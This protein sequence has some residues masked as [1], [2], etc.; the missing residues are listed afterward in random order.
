[1]ENIQENVQNTN[2]SELVLDFSASNITEFTYDLEK[3]CLFDAWFAR[4]VDLFE[5]D[6]SKLDDDAKVPLVLRNLN[7]TAHERYTSFIL[8]KPSKEFTF[9]ETFAQLKTIFGSP[10]STFHRR[11]QC[12][13]TAKEENED[14]ITY[15]CRVNRACVD[16]K[17]QVL[18]VEQLKA[19]IFVCGL[20][21]PKGVDI[22]MRLLSNI[23][24][25][26]DITLEKIVEKCKIMINLKKDTS[27]IGRKVPLA[28]VESEA[29]EGETEKQ[30][31]PRIKDCDSNNITRN[32]RYLETA[33]NE[34]PVEM[35]LGSGSGITIISKQN[36]INVG[37]PRTSPPDCK[38]QTASGDKLNI[39]AMFRATYTIG[40][41]HKE[42]PDL[43]DEFGLWD[44]PFSSFFKLVG[45]K[46]PD[47][48]VADLKP[49]FPDAFT[50]RMGRCT[51][52]QVHLTLKPAF[53]L[54]WPVSYNMEAVVEDEL[55]RLVN[56]GIITP[57]TYADWAALIVVVRKPDYPLPLPE[58]IF[59]RLANCKMFSHI[60]FS[61]AY[62]QV[63]LDEESR[64]FVT[65]T[66]T[67]GYR[68]N[69]ISPGVKC[70]SGAFQQI[71]DAMLSGLP[72]ASA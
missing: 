2:Q 14:F 61:D 31:L 20:R 23:N 34:V 68:F 65:I 72:C 43:M 54:N 21:S 4:Y 59:N 64:N 24:E 42:G 41:T 50:N 18:K 3:G 45:S 56:L 63:K 25:T 5:K 8:P 30:K 51:K 10:V 1:M 22:R 66:L 46:Q 57:V 69:R 38:V 28:T 58:D 29:I 32:W 55:K 12:L 15:S 6:A 16:F 35:Q 19:L 33:I 52:T 47:Q 40:E 9:E 39:E 70:A 48:Q 53:R 67:K 44:V 37:E 7:P 71:M 62:L 17:L 49:N 36:C 26:Q 11:Y 27:L 60:D 13:K